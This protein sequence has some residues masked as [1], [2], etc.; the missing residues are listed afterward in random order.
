MEQDEKWASGR[1]YLDTTE[2]FE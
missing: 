1:E 2:Y